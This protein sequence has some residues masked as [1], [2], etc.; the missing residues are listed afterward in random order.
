MLEARR[1]CHHRHATMVQAINADFGPADGWY[2]TW[3]CD[4]CGMS[5]MDKP[6]TL[7]DVDTGADLPWWDE[8]LFEDGVERACRSFW[9][10]ANLLSQA[11]R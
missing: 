6:V 11:A 10:T 8:Q 3:Q 7:A 1:L 5:I 9:A 4:D 2:V